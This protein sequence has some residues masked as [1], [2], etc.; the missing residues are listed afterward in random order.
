MITPA[1]PVSFQKDGKKW[2]IETFDP[3]RMRGRDLC[4]APTEHQEIN[5]TLRLHEKILSS[6][7]RNETTRWN[8]DREQA[9]ERHGRGDTCPHIHIVQY[10]M[11]C[12]CKSGLFCRTAQALSSNFGVFWD[13]LLFWKK[14]STFVKLWNFSWKPHNR[15]L[16][17]RKPVLSTSQNVVNVLLD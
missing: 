4:A 9:E 5:R 13:F 3:V 12:Q 7:V 2:A 17:L 11:S 15:S 6:H 14:K 10:N 1:G 16:P 8:T